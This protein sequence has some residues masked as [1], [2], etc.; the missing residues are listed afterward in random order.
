MDTLLAALPE[1]AENWAETP[2]PQRA[3]TLRQAAR[4]LRRNLE[5]HARL[6]SL[7]MGKLIAEARAEI[8]KCAWA[9]EFFAEQGGQY[10][11]DEP[12]ATEAKRS[13][14]A[15]EPLGTV[16]AIMPWN[17]PF[18]QVFRAAGPALLA[19]NTVLLKHAP[20]VTGCALAAESLLREAGLPAGAFQTLLIGVEPVPKLLADPR[21]HGLSFTGSLSAGRE[22]G[23][24]AG[25][26]I[27]K[28]VLELGGSDPFIVLEDAD[29]ERAARQAAASRFLNGGQ[30]C[31]AAKRF[32]VHEAVADEFVERF[33]ALAEAL[34]PGDPL[35]EAT[36]LPPLARADLRESLHRQVT[37][38]L[39][40][41]AVPV[42]G[43]SPIAGPGYFYAASLLDRVRPGMA[44]FDEEVFGPVAAVTR[45]RDDQEAIRLANQT[46]YGLGAS[47]WTADGE[48][49]ERMI[50]RLRCGM[51]FVNAI[52]KSDPRLPCGGVKD[53][54]YGRELAGQ[55]VREFTNVKTV[56]I[57]ESA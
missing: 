10:L 12:V 13:Y 41:G 27:K 45:V 36:T 48:R 40:A 2:L 57:A 20:S 22:V 43:C 26:N 9:L 16:L 15:Y 5:A 38:S 53:S 47:V 24:L 33:K 32:I 54:G 28:A 56:W 42:S 25:A 21:I 35:D 1:A 18:W 17:F 3:D 7:E 51:G 39:D 52:V 34:R 50:R 19:G 29:L 4:L 31:I 14:V 46:R 8:D 30:S 6:I 55:G 23:R 37:A 44:A 49:G 11:A